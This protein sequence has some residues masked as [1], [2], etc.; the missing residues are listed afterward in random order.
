V[1]Q[2]VIDKFLLRPR[3]ADDPR[4]SVKSIYAE[5][6]ISSMFEQKDANLEEVCNVARSRG[7]DVYTIAV[8][9]P[10]EGKAALEKCATGPS[11][12]HEIKGDDLNDAF[13]SIA[14]QIISLRLTN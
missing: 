3:Q 6:A 10:P 12:A 11:Y 13:A 8:S 5:M 2:Y 7:I 4:Q 14:A 9:A 1:V